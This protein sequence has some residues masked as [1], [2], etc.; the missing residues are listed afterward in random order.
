[1]RF[2]RRNGVICVFFLLCILVIPVPSVLGAGYYADLAIQVDSAG[3]VTI[4][5][6]TNHPDLL[7]KNTQNYTSKK[8]SYWLLNMTRTDVFS[9]YVYVV[10]LPEGSSINYL[11]SSGSIRIEEDQ[12]A[13]VVRGFGENKTLSF[14]VQYQ[15]GQP[16]DTAQ[17]LEI[18]YLYFIALVILAILFVVF[19]L[20][21]KRK[22]PPSTEVKE[23][24]L[25]GYDLKGLN[26]RQ[27]KILRLLQEKNIPLTQ[28]D[29][30]KE[31]QL[32]KASVSRNI[33]GLEHKGLIEKEQIGM[34]N[35]IRLKKL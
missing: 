22:T 25:G 23:E 29:I 28:T 26:D 31:L 9:D 19:F 7:I 13:L 27:K 32:P 12:G 18:N 8:Q 1:M 6:L 35:L 17:F 14:Q 20:F 30:Q 4:T 34:S 24:S 11:K 3:F 5:G 15:I 2:I 21:K 16:S 10:A 33:R